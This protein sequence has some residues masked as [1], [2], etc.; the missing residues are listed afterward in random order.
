MLLLKKQG[1]KTAK[2]QTNECKHA[3]KIKQ[4]KKKWAM[5]LLISNQWIW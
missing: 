2:L 1:K 5:Y 3:G 4:T